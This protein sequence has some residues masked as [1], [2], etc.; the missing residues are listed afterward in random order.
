MKDSVFYTMVAGIAIIAIVVLICGAVY[1]ADVT[2]C[3][4]CATVLLDGAS[5]SGWD[6]WVAKVSLT[7]RSRSLTGWP[8]THFKDYC[9]VDHMLADVTGI[10]DDTSDAGIPITIVPAEE[11]GHWYDFI[12]EWFCGVAEAQEMPA[13]AATEAIYDIYRV[14]EPVPLLPKGVIIDPDGPVAPDTPT[15]PPVVIY[16][17]TNGHMVAKDEAGAMVNFTTLGLNC[18]IMARDFGAMAKMLHKIGDMARG[19]EENE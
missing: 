7:T 9:N 17:D 8:E 12:I 13:I 10:I 1:G 5:D 6:V 4:Y 15:E 18:E 2:T 16:I 19:S 14:P 3:D 11:K